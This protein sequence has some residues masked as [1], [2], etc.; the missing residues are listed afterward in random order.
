M[1]AALLAHGE[2]RLGR[3]PQLVAQPHEF[4]PVRARNGRKNDV[5]GVFIAADIHLGSIFEAKLGRQLYGLN[6]IG[7][8]KLGGNGWHGA[9]LMVLAERS[10]L[11]Y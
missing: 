2:G 8:E 9:L 1:L 7:G 3:M 11:L 6:A 4:T 10:I 5:S